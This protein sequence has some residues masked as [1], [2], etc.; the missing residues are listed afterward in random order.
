MTMKTKKLFLFILSML[1]Y[2]GCHP[3]GKT[4]RDTVKDAPVE[5]GGANEDDHRETPETQ[6]P[7]QMETETPGDEEHQPEQR[8]QKQNPA[9]QKPGRIDLQ[10]ICQY[11]ELPTG[12]E[13]TSLAMV[14]NYNGISVD[15][16]ELADHYLDKGEVGTVDFRKAFEGDPRDDSS[17]GCYAPV[18]VNT[19]NKYLEAARSELRA[20]DISGCR[21]EELFPYIEAGVPVIIWGTLDCAEGYYSVTWNVDGTDISWYTP[22]HCR[23]LVG[24]EDGQVWTADPVY[25]DVRAYDIQVFESRYEDLGRQAVVIQ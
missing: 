20:A 5:T 9:E 17:Y 1:L 10:P 11:P 24:C 21:L 15:K 8:Q 18:I 6:A 22:E 7:L 16:C 14:L 3:L 2:T 4:G 12:C 13:I 19:A 25:G 23:V